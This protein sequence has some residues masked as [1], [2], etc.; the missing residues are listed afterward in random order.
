MLNYPVYQDKQDYFQKVNYQDYQLLQKKLHEVFIIAETQY[1]AFT[2]AVIQFK[3]IVAFF[4]VFFFAGGDN[5]AEI[6]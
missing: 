3:F 1:R 6:L 4:A 2:I 5:L